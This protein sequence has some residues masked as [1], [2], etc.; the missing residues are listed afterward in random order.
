MKKKTLFQICRLK[1]TKTLCHQMAVKRIVRKLQK[2]F[3]TREASIT[4]IQTKYSIIARVAPKM[5]QVKQS[6]TNNKQHH[7]MNEIKNL[8][9]STLLS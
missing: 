2:C 7:C 1:K 8:P 9:V 3:E 5:T 4:Q 6:A